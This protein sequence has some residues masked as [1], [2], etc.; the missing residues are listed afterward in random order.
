MWLPSPLFSIQSTKIDFWIVIWIVTLTI[1]HIAFCYKRILFF[2]CKYWNKKLL[3]FWP[4]FLKQ[5]RLV[6]VI[7]ETAI[8][9]ARVEKFFAEKE[10]NIL[11]QKNCKRCLS[12][13]QICVRLR[14]VNCEDVIKYKLSAS[15]FP[16]SAK[17]C[18][19]CKIFYGIFSLLFGN[20]KR[21]FLIF[22]ITEFLF[23]CSIPRSAIFSSSGASS[24]AV[25]TKFDAEV[26]E[27]AEKDALRYLKTFFVSFALKYADKEKKTLGSLR[28]QWLFF[29]CL[30]SHK[31]LSKRHC[32]L[33]FATVFSHRLQAF[34]RLF[35]H[36]RSRSKIRRNT[37]LL[38][39]GTS[40]TRVYRVATSWKNPGFFFAV[41][42][43]PWI[44]F[45]SPGKRL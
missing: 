31:T 28:A 5:R 18:K 17:K 41:L 38:F 43:S 25:S 15:V 6:L 14:S 40:A 42:E 27:V 34:S 1:I 23:S 24:G 22:E 13:E 33:W 7:T 10:W 39:F 11:R 19:Y 20:C 35:R 37:G 21:R 26:L 29:F 2:N 3:N 8:S 30:R 9:L 4:H 16:T 36:L 44:L 32:C 45:V 12:F